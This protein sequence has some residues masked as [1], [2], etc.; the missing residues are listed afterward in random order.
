VGLGLLMLQA[1][2]WYTPACVGVGIGRGVVAVARSS[3]GLQVAGWLKV[4]G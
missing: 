3:C 4:G 2:W 1:A